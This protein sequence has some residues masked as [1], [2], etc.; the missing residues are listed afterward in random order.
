[1]ENLGRVICNRYE[2]LWIS[3][4]EILGKGHLE[5]HVHWR[6]TD[7]SPQPSRMRDLVVLPVEQLPALLQHLKQATDLLT[8]RGL[9]DPTSSPEMVLMERGEVIVRG[10]P[11][12]MTGS[13]CRRHSRVPVQCAVV[14]R[15]LGSNQVES[16]PLL[17]GEIRD[18]SLGGAQAWLPSRVGLFQRVDVAALID[19]EPFRA[20]AE[21]VGADLPTRKHPGTGYLRHSFRWVEI[22]SKA[23]D[24]L[25]RTV[26][27]ALPSGNASADSPQQS[28]AA[29]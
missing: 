12:R 21:I 2:E 6:P 28:S 5:L 8:R 3:L 27:K 4:T 25:S 22:G 18:L 26:S 19:G 13:R 1:M 17:R 11:T 24:V 7:G 14:C 10:Q 9:L 20:R 29:H 16:S 23:K 15:P